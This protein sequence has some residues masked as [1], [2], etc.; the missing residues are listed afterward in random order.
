MDYAQQIKD[1]FESVNKKVDEK[2]DRHTAEV[3]EFGK[4]SKKTSDQLNDLLKQYNELETE[5]RSIGDS[6]T[7]LEQKGIQDDSP[8]ASAGLGSQ[9]VASEAFTNFKAGQTTRAS[10]T[11][12]NNTILEGTGN[13]VTRHEQLP[14]VVPGAFR[15][16]T[17]MPTVNTGTTSSNVI[18]YSRELLWTSNAAETGE[19]LAKPESDLTFEEIEENVRTIPHFIKVSKQALDDSSFLASYID[20]RMSHG[21]RQRIENQII[22]GDGTGVNLSGWLASGNNTVVSGIGTTDIFGLANAMKTAV[23]TAE[24]VPDYFYMNPADWSTAETIRRGAGDAAFVGASGAVTYV[25]NGLTPLLWGLPVVQSNAVPQGT[26]ICKSLD[27]D[28]YLNRNDV[29]VEM[30]EQDTDNVQKNLVTVRAEA[31]G[32]EAVM[33]P[34]AITSADITTIT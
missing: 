11:F 8:S 15:Q 34:A 9:F 30:F 6:M 13:S 19:G 24:Y 33:V 26:M 23:T 10:Q 12:Q 16:L 14:G 27:A 2:L 20:R 25:N 1:G 21:V 3:A 22:N 32:A 7:A 28:M 29:R 18:Y 5:M 31:R 4:A 17:V